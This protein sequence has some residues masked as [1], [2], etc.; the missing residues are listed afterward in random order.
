MTPRTRV[1][2]VLRLY[3]GLADSLDRGEW[4]PHG[5]PAVYKLLEALAARPE[6]ELE[7][8]FATK[9][10]FR[11][12]FARARSFVLPPIGGVHI[13]PYRP[14]RW[15]M[16]VGLDGPWRELRHL[17]ACL[18]LYSRFRPQVAYFAN[19]NMVPA[20]V[21]A[22]LGL[23]RTVL[24]FLGIFA[25]QKSIV[26]GRGKRLVRWLY[27]APFTRAICTM[28]GSGAEYYLPRL[29]RPGVPLDILLNGV[30]RRTVPPA[31]IAALRARL[32][33]GDGPVI[34]FL[35]RLE[36]YKGCEEFVEALL[37]LQALRPGGFSGLVVGDGSLRAALERKFAAADARIRFAGAIPHDDVPK[38]LAVTDVYVSLN[39]YGNV[40]NANLEAI[41]AGRCMILLEGDPALHVDDDTERLIP[42]DAVERVPRAGTVEALAVA[43]ARLVDDPGEITRRAAATSALGARILDSWERRVAREIELITEAAPRALTTTEE[44]VR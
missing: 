24:R 19:A 42:R 7:T 28:D 43:L 4:R 14:R 34:G 30:D 44:T 3:S 1:L 40:S 17:L 11:G 35:G 26:E 37:R 6:I 8:V 27:R 23:C 25:A 16:R 20:G 36:P 10:D 2:A 39:R 38:H 33:P 22:R 18:R 5:V 32:A 9:D 13:L 12:R 31:E 41:A 15:L 29:L 21:F